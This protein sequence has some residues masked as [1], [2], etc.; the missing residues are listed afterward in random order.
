MNDCHDVFRVDVTPDIVRINAHKTDN[1]FYHIGPWKSASYGITLV[2]HAHERHG[3]RPK[4]PIVLPF[5][6]RFNAQPAFCETHW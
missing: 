5:F 1:G 6:T 4:N 2:T 3:F